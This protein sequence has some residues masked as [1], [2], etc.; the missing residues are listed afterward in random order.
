MADSSSILFKRMTRY[1]FRRYVK[2]RKVLMKIRSKSGTY[3][4]YSA[5]YMRI[6]G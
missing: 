2:C 3:V 4:R 5:M 6:V 1:F